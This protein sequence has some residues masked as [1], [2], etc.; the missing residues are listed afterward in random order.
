MKRFIVFIS[1]LFL[2][3]ACGDSDEV[4]KVEAD[5]TAKA[6]EEKYGSVPLSWTVGI[7]SLYLIN[8]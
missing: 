7:S 1:L 6:E 5:N 2:I 4:D 3:S 8:N